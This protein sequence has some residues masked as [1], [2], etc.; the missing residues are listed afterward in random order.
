MSLDLKPISHAD[1]DIFK[2]I[3]NLGT[4]YVI[5]KNRASYRYE[6]FTIALDEVAE[7]GSFLEIELMASTIENLALIKQHMKTLLKGLSLEPLK[8]GYGTLLL[9]KKNFD[10][11]LLG[12]FILEEDKAHR[13]L[14]K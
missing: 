1:L 5:D 6:S 12:R 2:S 3:N 11:Y 9:R 10:H 13:A 8:T 4:H 14:P 7:L